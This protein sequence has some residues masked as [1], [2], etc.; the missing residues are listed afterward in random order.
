MRMSR[1][2][3]VSVIE[4]LAELRD[5]QLESWP[6][7]N[8]NYDA[9]VNV[10][11]K[12]AKIGGFESYLQFNP[13]RAV[14]TGAKIDAASIKARP[15]FLCR[16][17]RPKEQL[18]EE[19]LPGWEFLV[20]PY[21]IFPL[22]FTI[23]YAEHAPQDRVPLEMASIAEKLPGMTI[24]F[25]GARAGASAPDHLHLQAVMTSELPFLTYLEKGGAAEALPVNVE[26]F[27]IT[28][29][30]EGMRLLA[31]I[32]DI[33]GWDIMTGREDPGLVNVYMWIGKNGLLNVAVVRRSAHRPKCYVDDAGRGYM[34][35]PGAIDMVGVVILPRREDFEKISDEELT[36]IFSEVSAK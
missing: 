2:S 17:N 14:S 27:V 33:K 1:I 18:S 10:E 25:N 19:I 8:S 3:E 15:C 5:Y 20:N 26:H 9:L 24:F 11:R 22:H 6:M 28:P 34:I 23:A 12:T 36:E 35:S 29:D 30:A 13:A 31:A 32:P 16:S 7:A 21:P 4:A